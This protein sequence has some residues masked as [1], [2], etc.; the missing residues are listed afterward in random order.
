MTQRILLDILAEFFEREIVPSQGLYLHRAAQHWI[1]TTYTL[2]QSRIEPEIPVFERWK[3]VNPYNRGHC[4]QAPHKPYVGYRRVG[5][6]V[7]DYS[8]CWTTRVWLPERSGSFPLCH[9]IQ[10]GSGTHHCVSGTLSRELK[11]PGRRADPSRHIM[12]RLRMRGA[13]PPFTHPSS[14]LDA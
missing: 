14:W 7:Y 11:R 4:D 3:Y 9:C 6:S 8:T 2:T 12:Q 10:T 5:Q 1:T 13:I